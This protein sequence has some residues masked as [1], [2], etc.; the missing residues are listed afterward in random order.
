MRMVDVFLQ[1][2]LKV[3]KQV[4][5]AKSRLTKSHTVNIYLQ[6][7]VNTSVETHSVKLR[8]GLAMM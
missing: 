2:I 8:L 7:K 4:Y 1:F 5:K 6:R 3:P